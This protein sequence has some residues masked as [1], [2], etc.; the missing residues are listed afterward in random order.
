MYSRIL[1]ATDGS[2]LA[3]KGID[4]G[5]ALAKALGSSVI[6]L[7]VSEPWTPMGVD[8]AGLAVTEYALADEYEKAAEV[9]GKDILDKAMQNAKAAGVAAEPIYIGR[10]YPADGIIECAKTNNADLIVMASHGRRGLQRV[11]LGSQALQV[12]THST[13][14]VL[15]VR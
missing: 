13:V 8:A 11:L 7:T 15:V 9:A 10:K 4:Q 12:L 3:Q 14:P 5:L 1:I 6:L 2:A